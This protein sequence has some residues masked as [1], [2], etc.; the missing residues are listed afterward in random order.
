[1]KPS[2]NLLTMALFLSGASTQDDCPTWELTG[3]NSGCEEP[4]DYL[5]ESHDALS[6]QVFTPDQCDA[7]C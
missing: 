5:L 7:L 4:T 1:M 3:T 2:L 6:D